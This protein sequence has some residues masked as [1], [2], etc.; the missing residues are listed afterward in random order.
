MLDKIMNGWNIS[1]LSFRLFFKDIRLIFLSLLM[2][3]LQL[4]GWMILFKADVKDDDYFIIFGFIFFN[5]FIMNFFQSMITYIVYNTLTTNVTTLKE[6]LLLI[7]KRLSIILKW[8]LLD[9][10]VIFLLMMVKKFFEDSKLGFLLSFTN[11]IE[12]YGS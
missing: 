11:A 10:G 12:V 7:L 1:L 5:I 8:S 3:S 6:S 4:Y 9:S 2:V